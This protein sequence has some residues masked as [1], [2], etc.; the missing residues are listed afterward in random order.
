MEQNKKEYRKRYRIEH[1]ENLKEYNAQYKADHY[2]YIN[3]KHICNVCGGKYTT[4]HQKNHERT[5][6]HKKA[7]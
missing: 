7:T 3:E 2:D 6:K 5:N 4:K 1:A